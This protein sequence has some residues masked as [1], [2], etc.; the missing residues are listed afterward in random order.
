MRINEER[1][2]FLKLDERNAFLKLQFFS[3]KVFPGEDAHKRRDV[4]LAKN[5]VEGKRLYAIIISLQGWQQ[6]QTAFRL[7]SPT[8]TDAAPSIT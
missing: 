6:P 8:G 7:G 1:S 3:R 4:F 5:C 2:A